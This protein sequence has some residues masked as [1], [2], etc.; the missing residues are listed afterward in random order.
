[1]DFVKLLFNK[2]LGTYSYENASNIEMSNLS[3]FLTDD[4]GCSKEDS[5]KGF[6]LDNR[7][8]YTSSNATFLEKEDGYILL[9]S[10]HAEDLDNPIEFKIPI[11]MFIKL[12]DDWQEKVCKLKPKEVIIKYE[13][14]EFIFETKE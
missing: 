6:I 12:L 1:M 14:D 4:V 10:L 9:S 2:N 5:F 11:K 7:F 13:N 8:S 3:F